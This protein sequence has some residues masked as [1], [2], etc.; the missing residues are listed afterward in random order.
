MPQLDLTGQC[1]II[2]QI[3]NIYI[4]DNYTKTENQKIAK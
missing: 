2:T 4:L 3:H 1:K